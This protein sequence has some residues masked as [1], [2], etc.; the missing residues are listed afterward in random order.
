[1]IP[2]LMAEE[3][4]RMEWSSPRMGKAEGGVGFQGKMRRSTLGLSLRCSL[5]IQ[6]EMPRKF[7]GW[8]SLELK[9]GVFSI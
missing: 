1:M 2:T 8:M 4:G 3:T 9:S 6:V 5:H 7:W